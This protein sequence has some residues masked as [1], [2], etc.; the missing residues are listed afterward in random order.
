M[1]VDGQGISLVSPSMVVSVQPTLSLQVQL[2]ASGLQL[3]LVPPAHFAVPPL[4]SCA[5]TFG[6]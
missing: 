6:G 3:T 1:Y 5:T 4:I 2:T